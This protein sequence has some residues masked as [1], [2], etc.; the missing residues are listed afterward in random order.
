MVSLQEGSP[1]E[2]VASVRQAQVTRLQQFSQLSYLRAVVQ[3]MEPL[4]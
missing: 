2:L 1:L 4:Y 3:Q